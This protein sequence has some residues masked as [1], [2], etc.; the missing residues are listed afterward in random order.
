MKLTLRPLKHVDV[1]TVQGR[2]DGE[3][4]TEFENALRGLV[5]RNRKK[6]I[7]DMHATD[8]INSGAL[9]AM[10]SA[11]K[12]CKRTSGNVVLAG[13]NERVRDTL[14]LVGF[15]TLFEQFSDVVEAVDSFQ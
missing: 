2:V 11:L 7:L 8:F 3:G 15:E 10:V 12:E 4:V 13:S 9:R 6:I 1:L 14:R 5:E